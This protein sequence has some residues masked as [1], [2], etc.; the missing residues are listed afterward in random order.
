MEL[1]FDEAMA[2]ELLGI[3]SKFGFDK[4]LKDFT[5]SNYE[6][7][8]RKILSSDADVSSMDGVDDGCIFYGSNYDVHVAS[9]ASKVVFWTDCGDSVFKMGF[10]KLRCDYC[11]LEAEYFAEAKKLGLDEF[12]AA[13]E[14][15]MY[16][17]GIRIYKAERAEV[18]FERLSSDLYEKLKSDGM[19][20]DTI[21]D[22][23][24]EADS[25]C[26]FMNWLVPYYTDSEKAD[27][28]FEF[29][30][31]SDINDLHSGNIGYIGNRLVLIDYSGYRG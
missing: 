12:F 30:N 15:V 9:G 29:L 14:F 25:C 6:D 19:D 21:S 8:I 13:T 18:S 16:Y 28:L 3:L 1:T 2:T 10:N 22:T 24:D 20:E 27:E 5:R 23:I 4:V 31:E 7:W 26:E 11:G 17:N